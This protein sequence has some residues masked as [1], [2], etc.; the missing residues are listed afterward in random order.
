MKTGISAFISSQRKKVK[1]FFKG[2]KK[3]SF[4]TQLGHEWLFEERSFSYISRNLA[5]ESTDYQTSLFYEFAKYQKIKGKRVLEIGS[6][7][8]LNTARMFME[9]GAKEVHACNLQ[10]IFTRSKASDSI[11]L[12]VGDAG[13]LDLGSEAFDIIYGIA[14]LEHVPE[15]EPLSKTIARLLSFDGVA[16]LHG[17]PLWTGPL[18]HHVYCVSDDETGNVKYRFNDSALNPIPDWAHLTMSPA[19][20][21]DYLES[22]GLPLTD[23]KEIVEFVY[24]LDSNAIGDCSNQKSAREVQAAFTSLFDLVAFIGIHE[25]EKNQFFYEALREYSEDDLLAKGMTLWLRHKK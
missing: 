5:S 22:K 25:G 1:R 14:L 7:G 11:Y 6:D 8:N 9:H 23:A 20:L 18:G 12:H 13:N 16:Y 10:D 24:G 15:Y 19:A 21:L 17:D 3:F 2:K 4:K